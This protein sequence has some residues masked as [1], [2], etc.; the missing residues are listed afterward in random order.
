M[1]EFSVVYK[2]FSTTM[3][4]LPENIPG[5]L[6]LSNEVLLAV[7][8][9]CRN[10]EQKHLNDTISSLRLTCWRFCLLCSDYAICRCATLDFSRPESPKLFRQVVS[11]PRI[12]E[13]VCKV[14]VRLHFYHPWIAAS[15]DNFISAILSEWEQ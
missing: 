14:N 10:T 9:L 8:G 5:F 3:T 6:S 12:A 1:S 11:N 13:G 15:L 7:F 2:P 4:A